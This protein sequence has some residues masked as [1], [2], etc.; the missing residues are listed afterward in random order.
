MATPTPAIPTFTD[1]MLV[2]ATD[3]NG[4]ASNLTNL[5]NYTNASFISQRPCVI[6]KQTTGQSI[7]NAA[8]TLV[9]FQSAA[10]NTDNMWTAS[11]P[12]QLTINHAGI[13]LLYSQTRYGAVANNLAYAVTTSLLVN[14]TAVPGN[15]VST[16]AQIPPSVGAGT[17]LM[18]ISLVNLAAGSTVFLNAW[19]A[20]GGAAVTLD[21]AYGGTYIGA[22]FLTPST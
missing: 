2:H 18:C 19:Q 9:N 6:A 22:V 15:A 10:V 13:Y 16:Q 5:Y 1:G 12:S 11:V 14:G 21:T 7:P 20:T 3:L 17:A 4:L 8:N